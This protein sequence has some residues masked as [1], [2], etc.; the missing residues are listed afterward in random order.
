MEKP[1]TELLNVLNQLKPSDMDEFIQK[2]GKKTGNGAIFSEYI[3]EHNI[4]VSE[5]VRRS[6]G[7][8]SKSY[9]YDILGGVKKN[10]SRDILMILCIACRMDR[11]YVRRVLENYGQRDLYVKDTRDIIIATYINNRIYDLDQLNDELFRYDLPTLNAASYEEEKK[12]QGGSRE[13]G[14]AQNPG[15]PVGKMERKD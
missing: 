7:L 6:K 15:F 11:K 14:A 1:T 2:Y 10:P 8:V 12:F 3:A 9:I 13:K 5:I 4:A